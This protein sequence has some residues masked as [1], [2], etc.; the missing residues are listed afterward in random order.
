MRRRCLHCIS[1][2]HGDFEIGLDFD[3][4]R[5]YRDVKRTLA[6]RTPSHSTAKLFTTQNLKSNV[7]N[8]PRHF[9]VCQ[10]CRGMFWEM[11][12]WRNNLLGKLISHICHLFLTIVYCKWCI[13]ENNSFQYYSFLYSK[14]SL[15]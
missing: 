12:K 4:V 2:R 6:T 11:T 5:R 14:V 3:T 13:I 9:S 1:E 8:N 15:N 7:L 10:V